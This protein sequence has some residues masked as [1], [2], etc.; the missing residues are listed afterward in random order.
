MTTT[1]AS[2]G[3]HWAIF[4]RVAQTASFSRAATELGLSKATVSKAVSRLFYF[5]A[6]RQVLDCRH[7]KAARLNL[8][9]AA[10]G[11]LGHDHHPRLR[12]EVVGARIVEVDGLLHEAQPEDPSVE[13]EVAA[14]RARVRPARS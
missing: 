1:H 5:G 4:A 11:A 7:R 2:A 12:R 3:L 10:P 6:R 8:P 14:R 9:A 13:V